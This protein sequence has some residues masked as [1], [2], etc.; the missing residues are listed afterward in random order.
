MNPDMSSLDQ[1]QLRS[2]LEAQLEGPWMMQLML[3]AQALMTS[4]Q[5]LVKV[6]NIRSSETNTNLILL[7]NSQ[8][9]DRITQMIHK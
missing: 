9:L 6:L 2:G 5:E 7:T 8:D 3:Q 4:N 1:D